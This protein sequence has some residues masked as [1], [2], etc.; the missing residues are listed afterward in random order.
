MYKDVF[1]ALKCLNYVCV[2]VCIYSVLICYVSSHIVFLL[3][4]PLAVPTSGDVCACQ[5][6]L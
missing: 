1:S 6:Y 4:A 2:C 3:Q 5:P